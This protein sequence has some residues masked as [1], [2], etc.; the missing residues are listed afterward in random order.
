MIKLIALTMMV[1]FALLLGLRDSEAGEFQVMKLDEASIYYKKYHPS[2]RH[3]LF[4]D[5]SPKESLNLGTNVDLLQVIGWDSVVQSMTNDSQYYMV[6]LQMQLYLRITQQLEVGYY[7][8]SQHLLDHTYPYQ[9]YPVEDA[10]TVR[11]T[12]FR[13]HPGRSSLF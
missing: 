8:Q 3:P 4:Y 9:R 10:V 11:L 6:G 7:H 13:A 5:S 12:L 2:A 1:V